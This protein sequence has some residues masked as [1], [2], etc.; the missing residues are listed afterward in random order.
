MLKL[1]GMAFLNKGRIDFT[2]DDNP[3]AFSRI[4]AG[5]KESQRDRI[6]VD[7][8]Q[9][10][11]ELHS[12]PANNGTTPPWMAEM[13]EI[14][15]TADSLCL[16]FKSGVLRFR[17][18]THFFGP[19]REYVTLG[20]QDEFDLYA[21][22]HWQFIR[23]LYAVRRPN[24]VCFDVNTM[25]SHRLPYDQPTKRIEIPA[26]LDNRHPNGELHVSFDSS[27]TNAS[28]EIVEWRG[29]IKEGEIGRYAPEN[30]HIEFSVDQITRPFTF[31]HEDRKEF[32]NHSFTFDGNNIRDQFKRLVKKRLSQL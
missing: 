26:R 5:M 3:W 23:Y 20:N 24:A 28:M 1:I 13:Q 8:K 10:P 16:Q 17:R 29:T 32:H 25:I 19:D 2:R 6:A 4:D 7:P 18:A 30:S 15:K 27:G 22:Q 11:I 14:L 9:A 12:A 21:Q 31:L